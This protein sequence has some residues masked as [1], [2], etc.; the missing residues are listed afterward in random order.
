M[1]K[2]F[3]VSV[4][5][6]A[7]AGCASSGSAP[8]VSDLSVSRN[9]QPQESVTVQSGDTLYGIAWRNN[10]DFREL[11]R[12]NGISPPYRIEP[13]QTLRLDAGAGSQG[14]ALAS[15]GA[16]GTQASAMG[17]ASSPQAAEQNP[18][19][20]APDT[21][22]I[23]RN[24]QL[25]SEPLTG[26]ATSQVP[27]SQALAAAAGAGGASGPGPIYNFESPGADG[28]LSERERQEQAAIARERAQRA[29][30]EAAN[31]TNRAASAGQVAATDTQASSSSATTDSQQRSTTSGQTASDAPQ[32]G[33][34]APNATDAG[35]AVAGEANEP[36]TQQRSYSPVEN[37][38]W[39][40]PAEG[41]VVGRFGD[42][43]NITA[44]IDIAGQKGQP[45]RAAGPG[46]VVY[47][48]DGVRGYGNLILLKHND[49]FL[50]AYAHNDTLRVKEN[51]VV[52]AGEVI[53]TMG[54]TDADGVKLHFEVRKEGQPQDPLEYLPSR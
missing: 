46:I 26:G 16:S 6:L 39:Q 50:S 15:A 24:R 38:P 7:V 9:Q 10:M 48:G 4:L 52:K 29:E 42:G 31:A 5:T 35:T 19:W 54:N 40:W 33:S 17:N 28:Q 37:I 32:T 13:G 8:Q 34:A 1:R 22:T 51:D 14:Q 27:S 53:A 41:E 45:I 47:A 11:A 23:E 44:G 21:Q 3:L 36:N 25:S 43:S 49:R 20:L 12:I 18:D 30:A 2:A